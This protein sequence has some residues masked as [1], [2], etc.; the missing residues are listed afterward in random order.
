MTLLSGGTL[1]PNLKSEK[2]YKSNSI[3]ARFGMVT[4]L[5]Y[6]DMD[7]R[8]NRYYRESIPKLNE[9]VDLM[10][11]E[12]V[13]FLIEM[14]DF[15]DIKDKDVQQTLQF[16]KDI[17]SEFRKFNGP[18]YHVMGNHDMDFI[19]KIQFLNEIR[20]AGFPYAQSYYSFNSGL[21][22]FVVLDAN[23]TSDGKPYDSGRFDW[24]DCFIPKRQLSWLEGDLRENDKPTIIFC[25]QLLDAPGYPTKLA[26]FF[27]SNSAEVR[28][29]LEDSGKI[30]AVFQGHYH[31]GGFSVINDIPYY[32]LKALIEGSGESNNSYAI[33]EVENDFSIRIKGYRTATSEELKPKKV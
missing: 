13:D 10:N 9:C 23:F 32:T 17:E 6:A 15:K 25:H 33:V 20:N 5:H 27:P 21:V 12:K 7:P 14:G 11:Q 28:K 2:Q 8:I 3:I 30:L 24:K 16:L 29:I 4:D 31:K 26:H 1:V 18:R 19:S 22:H